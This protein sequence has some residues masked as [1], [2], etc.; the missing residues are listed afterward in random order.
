MDL[1]TSVLESTIVQAIYGITTTDITNFKYKSATPTNRRLMIGDIKIMAQSGSAVSISYT[2]T[3]FYVG[4]TSE[5]MSSDL[6]SS[7]SSNQFNTNLNQNAVAMGATALVGCSS[8][9]PVTSD[10]LY[11]DGGNHSDTVSVAVIAGIVIAVVI[12]VILLACIVRYCVLSK[13]SSSGSNTNQSNPTADPVF[14]ISAISGNKHH[15]VED[16]G[17]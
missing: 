7:V 6:T 15:N 10:S 12:L 11:T 14:G 5:T 8:A 4:V 3:S 17:L 9:L 16:S 2:V 1:Y 13:H